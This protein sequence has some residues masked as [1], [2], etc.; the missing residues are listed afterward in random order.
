M[1]LMLQIQQEKSEAHGTQRQ[2][3][4]DPECHWGVEAK[5]NL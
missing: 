4:E 3:A 2:F 1:K 5:I